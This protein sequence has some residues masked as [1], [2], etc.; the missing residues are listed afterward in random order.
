[1]RAEVLAVVAAEHERQALHSARRRAV[2]RAAAAAAT[3]TAAAAPGHRAAH[4]SDTLAG[5]DSLGEGA[6]GEE[7]PP[8]ALAAGQP[9]R[10]HVS[11]ELPGAGGSTGSHGRRGADWTWVPLTDAEVAGQVD[12]QRMLHAAHTY[13][14]HVLADMRTQL[15]DGELLRLA[16]G[17]SWRQ[18][19][20]AL[21]MHGR[22]HRGGGG[23]DLVS[24]AVLP[25]LP[26]CAALPSGQLASSDDATAAAA[27]PLVAG[28]EG[29]LL[30]VCPSAVESGQLSPSISSDASGATTDFVSPFASGGSV[31]RG[32]AAAER[33]EDEEFEAAA[34]AQR[35]PPHLPP[36]G[37][38]LHRVKSRR[39]VCCWCLPAAL[40][41]PRPPTAAALPHAA[42]CR[43]CPFPPPRNRRL[44]AAS[45]EPRWRRG[46]SLM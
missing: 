33:R 42:S 2:R 34:A 30:I 3:A 45:G 20:H 40:G 17:A 5:S 14:R 12:R 46:R 4:E 37:A 7:A 18:R 35:Q 24:P 29:A 39:C 8:L 9:G 16:P 21:L 22:L 10:R 41:E 36:V 31:L 1:M 27:A 38:P 19:S 13:A 25:W 15:C 28:S 43:P 6:G 11:W 23:S 32:G 44:Q 26:A